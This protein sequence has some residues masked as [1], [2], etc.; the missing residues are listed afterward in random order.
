[1]LPDDLCSWSKR[2]IASIRVW[3]GDRRKKWHG[4]WMSGIGG[5]MIWNLKRD[6]IEMRCSESVSQPK[7]KS[8]SPIFIVTFVCRSDQSIFRIRDQVFLSAF[9]FRLTIFQTSEVSTTIPSPALS[10][11]FAARVFL[12]VSWLFI[13]YS[14]ILHTIQRK[15]ENYL[16]K[17]YPEFM[18]LMRSILVKK[19]KSELDLKTVDDLRWFN[20]YEAN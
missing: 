11:D 18:D 20:K 17:G 12:S 3:R 8:N 5:W 7:I 10:S 1:M 16:L 14:A 9:D 15:I 2:R 6:D 19:T 13:L 4:F